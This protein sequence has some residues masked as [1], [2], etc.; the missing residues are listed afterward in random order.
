MDDSRQCISMERELL[1]KGKPNKNRK[2]MMMYACM[3]VYMYV[4]YV[5]LYVCM[6]A[7]RTMHVFDI[8][9]VY[10]YVY[11]CVDVICMFSLILLNI[12]IVTPI[13]ITI[14]DMDH[15]YAVAK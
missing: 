3:H 15:T 5:C 1:T 10:I 2:Y 4:L 11:M 13:N 6:Y 7:C 8:M 12:Q 9:Y 14:R